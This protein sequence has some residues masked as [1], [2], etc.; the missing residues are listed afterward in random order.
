MKSLEPDDLFALQYLRDARLDRDG[1]QVA[2]AV[3]RTDDEE[4]FE[5]WILNLKTG[6]RQRLP[7]TANAT[8]PRWSP[9]GRWLAFV[10]D[11]R[12]RTA[13]LP[14]LRISDPLTP[15]HL[16]V[17]G[18]PSWAPDSSRLAVC[19]LKHNTLEGPRR[20]TTNTFRSDGLGYLDSFSQDLYVVDRSRGGLSCLISNEGICSQAQWSPCGR[21]ILFFATGGA[22]PV[23]SYA[24]RLLTVHIEG[25]EINE[26][27]GPRWYVACARWLPGGERIAIAAARDSTLTIPTLSLWVVDRTGDN[28]ELRTQG[29]GCLGCW[30]H[31]D[32]P[33]WDFM[34]GVS[35]FVV[36]D[37]QTAYASVQTGG[38]V[39]IWKVALEGEIAVERVLTG[40]R[41]C[42]VLEARRDADCLLYATT[43]LCSPTELCSASL[44]TYREN[45]LTKLNDTVLESWPTTDV[46][47]FVFES[48]DGTPIEAWFMSPAQ[49]TRPLPTVLFIHGGPFGATGY[50]FRYDFHLLAAQGYGIVFANFRG[51]AGYG[52]PFVRAI[53]GDW[54]GRGYPDHIGAVEAAVAHGFA[55]PERLGVWGPSYG[56]SATCWIVGHTN[57]FKAAIAE[58]PG[59]NF[60]M[61]YYLSDA[62]EIYR[63]DL[64]GRPHEIPDVY[65]ACSPITYAH[66]C[67]TPTML[68]HGEDDFRCPISES[69]Q[70]YGVLRDV[71]CVTE[72]FRIPDCSH[73]GDSVGPL[74]ARRAQ[75]E[76]LVSWF[77]QHL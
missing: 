62:R 31:H 16:T 38:S 35:S 32:M 22:S 61:R 6:E 30:V 40:N 27:L 23:A 36:C 10:A 64:G 68:L 29:T 4:R 14:T 77:G 56:G 43:D 76:A 65:R 53:M 55:D 15:E 57:R 34:Y 52:D 25:G 1:R 19:L 2:Y 42:L 3:S 58:A 41:A 21:R 39:E 71:G 49:R 44:D 75:N 13:A 60:T 7:Y 72:L 50:A 11:G 17:Q 28:A 5:I 37:P 12:L 73:L 69:E 48:G 63:R 54:C 26:V 74:S 18:A 51:S 33:V 8:S 59:T 70:F 9:D 46:E 66:H 67:T 24:S 20:I 47:R 45:R